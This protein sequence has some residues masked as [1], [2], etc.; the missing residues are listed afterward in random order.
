MNKNRYPAIF[1]VLF[2]PLLIGCTNFM[3]SIYDNDKQIS[4]TTNS[5]SIES[6][7]QTLND[8]ELK[9]TVKKMVG[10][11]KVWTYDSDEDSD[12]DITYMFKVKSGKVKL[13]LIHP[14]D[15]VE[16]IVETTKDSEVSDTAT[17]TLHLKK[18][19]NRI[20]IVAAEDT[21]FEFDINV[22]KGKLKKLG[23]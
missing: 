2:I 12:I 8:T 7:D 4:R 18:G 10:M 1:M 5:F 23:F 15:S 21:S 6:D 11:D 22:P 9:G 17:S 14:D 13:A 16:T 19:T 3:N 20:K